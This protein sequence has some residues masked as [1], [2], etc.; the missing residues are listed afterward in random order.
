MRRG[1]RCP[2]GHDIRLM[3]CQLWVYIRH[4]HIRRLPVTL[5]LEVES[6]TCALAVLS[7]APELQHFDAI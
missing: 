2:R 4:E 5:E 6:I 1:G 7:R 3:L